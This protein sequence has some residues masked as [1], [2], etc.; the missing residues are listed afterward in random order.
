MPFKFTSTQETKKLITDKKGNDYIDFLEKDI[1]YAIG[2]SGPIA[3]NYY[4][5]PD[6]NVMRPDLVTIDMYVVVDDYM[7]MLLKFNGISNPLAIDKDDIFVMY[8]PYSTSKNMRNSGTNLEAKNDVRE[9]YL[10]PEKKSKI[11]PKLKEFEK[12]N[13][14][15]IKVESTNLPPNYAAFGDKEIEI[16]GGKIYF[17]PNVSKSI[18]EVGNSISKSDFIA[19]LVKNGKK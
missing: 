1:N 5:V 4:F 13:K 14:Q 12:R 15:S 10:S 2:D 18:T 3:I 19:R 11:D 9:Q 7:E 6:S 16:K 8:E 17:G